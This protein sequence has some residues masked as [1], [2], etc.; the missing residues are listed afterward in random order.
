[1]K[2]LKAAVDGLKFYVSLAVMFGILLL[3]NMFFPN[4]LPFKIFQFFRFDFS[5]DKLV[6]VPWTLLLF[7]PGLAL[8]VAIFTKNSKSQRQEIKND[9]A[10]DMFTSIKAGIFEE[11]SFRWLLFF[12]LIFIFKGYDALYSWL[13]TMSLTNAILGLQWW[14]VIIILVVAN[15]IG[16]ICAGVL[17]E[18]DGCLAKAIAIIVG[19]AVILIDLM[20]IVSVTKW[21]YTA[22]IIPFIDIV[23]L[24]KLTTQLYQYGWFVGA[25]LISSN[26][27]FGQGHTYQGCLGWLNSWIIGMLMFYFVFN[28]GLLF[29]M[30]IHALYDIVITLIIGVD[31]QLERD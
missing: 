9:F 23:T 8:I 18:V 14:A 11:T 5:W 12:Y 30:A 6:G 10:K 31:A 24:G 26:W 22:A 7:G 16:V 29:A 17:K 3:L 21:L 2:K 25:A 27:Q 28:F 15:L 19:T 1:M 20:I 13:Q 4:V